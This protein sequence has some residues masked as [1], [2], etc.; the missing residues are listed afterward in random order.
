MLSCRV[1]SRG[2]TVRARSRLDTGARETKRRDTNDRDGSV[3]HG[4]R[5]AAGHIG[6]ATVPDWRGRR[7]IEP[8][9]RDF[10]DASRHARRPRPRRTGR[11]QIG[12][13]QRISG[14]YYRTA[15]S[16]PRSMLVRYP[17]VDEY[18]KN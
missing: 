11:L 16:K 3:S 14:A 17:L 6:V 13:S 15:D 9:Q 4:H 7:S 12:W 1:R 10:R 5:Q 2:Y 8:K 18:G